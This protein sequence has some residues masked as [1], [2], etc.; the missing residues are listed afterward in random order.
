MI[1]TGIFGGS[2]HPIHYG[3]IAVA[4]YFHRSG[5]LDEVWF[6]VS[7]L[8]PLKQDHVMSGAEERL[9]QVRQALKDYPWLQVCD[10]ELRLPRP[11]Y[12]TQTLQALSENYPDRIFSLI[13][14]GD[15]LDKFAHWKNY[16]Y[17]LAHYDILVYPRPGATNKV[18]EGWDRVRLFADAP[19]MDISSTLIRQGLRKD[20]Q[21]PDN[22][23][24]DL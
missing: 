1:R 8:N 17:I 20:G 14:G 19:Q 11:S 24:A 18:P 10:I 4:D 21:D 2:F 15:N 5:L 23:N 12:T 6:V 13:I 22:Q 9:E 16:E 3:H 7:P